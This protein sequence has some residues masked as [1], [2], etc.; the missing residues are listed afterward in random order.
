[1]RPLEETALAFD[2]AAR[3]AM[4]PYALVGGFAVSA[5]GQP[6]STSDVDALV[7]LPDAKVESFA[8][9]IRHEGLTVSMADLRDVLRQGG[10]V[11]IFDPESSFHVDAKLCRTASEREQVE[12]AAEVP[13]HGAKLRFARAEDTVAYKLLYG[14]PQDVNDAATI[15]ARQAGKLDEGR[16]MSIALKLGVAPALRELEAK[17]QRGLKGER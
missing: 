4:V 16:L 1:M 8:A 11:T 17:V 7:V 15:L 12:Q 9:A 13:F 2:R 6:R 14:T 3:A 10:H 5:W